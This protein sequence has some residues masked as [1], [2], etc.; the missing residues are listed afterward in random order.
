MPP[1]DNRDD[2]SDGTDIC[3]LEWLVWALD[4]AREH[5]AAQPVPVPEELQCG[6]PDR[7]VRG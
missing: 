3:R 7:P 1:S 2:A 5:C 6:E 4:A